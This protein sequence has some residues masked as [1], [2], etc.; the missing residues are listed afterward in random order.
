MEDRQCV[1]QF[2]SICKL[3]GLSYTAE[4]GTYYVEN[5]GTFCDC[6]GSG[7]DTVST[8]RD[9]SCQSCNR[10][11]TVCSINER[12]N[13]RF[14]ADGNL[15]YYNVTFQYVKGRND[16]VV[17]EVTPVDWQCNVTVNDEQCNSCRLEG[18]GNRFLGFQGYS[19]SCDNVINESTGFHGGNAGGSFSLCGEERDDYDSP[20][21]MF[22]VQDPVFRDGCPPRI[23]GR[24][25][26]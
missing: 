12:Y 1:T 22:A 25:N 11:G 16:T 24:Q 23:W 18:C 13:T 9:T 19:V 4:T 15:V 26:T 7:V 14:D 6:L 3:N 2:D 10:D 8:C 17:F 21:T 20:L 5:T